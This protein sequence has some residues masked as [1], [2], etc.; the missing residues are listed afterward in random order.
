MQNIQD[1]RGLLETECRAR[2]PK[3]MEAVDRALRD[4]GAMSLEAARLMFEFGFGSP[5]NGTRE[6]VKDE[7]MRF[8]EEVEESSKADVANVDDQGDAP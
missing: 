6:V 2:L 7:L 1:E 3:A 5:Q 8:L 4:G